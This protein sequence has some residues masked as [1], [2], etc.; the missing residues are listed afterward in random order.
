MGANAA[1]MSGSG[2]SVFGIFESE[3]IAKQA[4]RELEDKYPYVFLTITI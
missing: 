1:L 4:H 2:P 3:E